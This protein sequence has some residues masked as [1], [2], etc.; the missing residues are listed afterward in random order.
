MPRAYISIGSNI[1]PERHIDA[2]LRA[3]RQEFDV[4]SVSP[5]Y[6][7]KAE[8]FD[9]EDF[10]NVAV[11]IDSALKPAPIVE[12]LTRIEDDN[13][14]T[15]GG[16]RFAARTLDLDLL[17]Y[18]DEVIDIGNLH[19]PRPEILRYAFVLKPLADIAGT[20]RHPVVGERY[21]DLWEGFDDVGQVLWPVDVAA[22]Q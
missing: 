20:D 7:S 10:L 21:A 5:V 15:R 13:G 2:A 16:A 17:T 8:G 18:G 4:R 9:G 3:L 11:A 22:S 1:E 19:L 6:R 14:R 12:I